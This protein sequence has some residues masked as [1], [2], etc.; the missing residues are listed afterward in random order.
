MIDGIRIAVWRPGKNLGKDEDGIEMFEQYI[1]N[2]LH[3]DTLS[4]KMM[5][6]RNSHGEKIYRS[7]TAFLESHP[8]SSVAIWHAIK[9]QRQTDRF[10]DDDAEFHLELNNIEWNEDG[11]RVKE[12]EKITY[13][14][15]SGEQDVSDSSNIVVSHRRVK[16]AQSTTKAGFHQQGLAAKSTAANV[17]TN[18][19]DV[20][21]GDVDESTMHDPENEIRPDKKIK[22][23]RR[24]FKLNN[25]P[26][27]ALTV[28]SSEEDSDLAVN[29]GNRKGWGL[30]RMEEH[31]LPGKMGEGV[32]RVQESNILKNVTKRNGRK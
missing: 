28:S 15:D 21:M 12:V 23:E 5:R 26:Q 4:E 2:F 10:Q 18:N 24:P 6:L 8:E 17:G 29:E 7:V 3:H 32:A 19:G 30:V 9:E 13:T 14:S 20:D 27:T 25:T 31:A 11:S 16:Q 1:S 22:K